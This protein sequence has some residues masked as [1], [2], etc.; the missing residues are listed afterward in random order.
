VIARN[1]DVGQTVAASLQAPTLFTIAQDLTKM[2]VYA[3]TDE[4]DVGMIKQAQV[5]TF[6]VDAFPRDTFTGRVSQIRMNAIT[7]QNVVT[8][9]T[10]IDF[11]NPDLKLS[12]DAGNDERLRK[13]VGAA[14]FRLGDLQGYPF[15][16]NLGDTAGAMQSYRS[17]AALLDP[18]RQERILVSIGA[19]MWGGSLNRKLST[20]HFLFLREPELRRFF[21]QSV[22]LPSY[23]YPTS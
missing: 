5:V 20:G 23:F 7:V 12:K 22:P 19:E 9:N 4:S 17:S 10:V 8:Y 1:V 15:T 18:L 16:P 2:Q 11:D 6:K 14:Y 21:G 13:I 3:S